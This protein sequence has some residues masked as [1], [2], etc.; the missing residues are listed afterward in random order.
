M[1][2]DINIELPIDLDTDLEIYK[3]DKNS[4]PF[5]HIISGDRDIKICL[6]ESKY[7]GENKYKLTIDEA[8]ELDDYLRN[9]SDNYNGT[10][11]EFAKSLW[12]QENG[13]TIFV[14]EQPDYTKLIDQ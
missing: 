11:W 5:F 13:E 2:F 3:E 10:V 6:N 14:N 7:Y 8:K 12:I 1:S 9:T 4:E